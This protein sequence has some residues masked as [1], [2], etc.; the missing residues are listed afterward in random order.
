MHRGNAVYR[1]L[2]EAAH[3]KPRQGAF[4][5]GA[6]HTAVGDNEACRPVVRTHLRRDG[7][8]GNGSDYTVAG[9]QSKIHNGYVHTIRRLGGVRGEVA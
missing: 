9:L 5:R 8:R 7:Q 4:V 2:P 6:V 1:L 3:Y